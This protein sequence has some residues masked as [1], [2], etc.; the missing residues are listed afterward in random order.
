MDRHVV[1]EVNQELEKMH[2]YSTMIDL[3][4]MPKDEDKHYKL[5]NKY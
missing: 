3:V 4:I 2:R 5:M 1:V